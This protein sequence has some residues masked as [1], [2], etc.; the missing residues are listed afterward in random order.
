MR[1][2]R[3]IS[4]ILQGKSPDQIPMVRLGE[5]LQQLAIMLGEEDGVHFARVEKGSTKVVATLDAGQPAQNVH[6]RA[7]AVRDGRA[8]R[9]SMNAFRR[10]EEMVA[11]DGG[12]ARLQFG[13]ATVLRFTGR[14][15]LKAGAFK[16]IDTGTVTGRLYSLSEGSDQSIRGRIRPQF[17]SGYISCTAGPEFSAILRRHLFE[18]VRVTGKGEWTRSEEGGWTCQ[19]LDVIEVKPVKNTTL[20]EAI[21]TLRAIDAQWGDDP[22]AEWEEME[23]KDGAA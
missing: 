10:I 5:Y 12:R 3:E 19:H 16:L 17:G 22:L 21:E 11:Q 8:P 9:D 7:Y 15:I 23:M 4:W 18:A 2:G 20:R 13:T 14:N 1:I 6:A